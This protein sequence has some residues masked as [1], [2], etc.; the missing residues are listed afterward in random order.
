MVRFG[1]SRERMTKT[2]HEDEVEGYGCRLLRIEAMTYAVR[3]KNARVISQP[4]V[5][6]I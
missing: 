4:G 5:F 3:K 1:Q 2:N 6:E